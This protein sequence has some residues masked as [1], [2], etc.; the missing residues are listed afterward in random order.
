MKARAIAFYLPQYHPIPENDRWWGEGFTEWTN[1]RKANPLFRGHLQPRVPGSLGYYSLLSP[2]TRQ[3]QAELAALHGV[4]GFCYWHYWFAGKRLLERPFEEVLHSGQPALPFCL[5]WANESWTGIWH[6]APNRLLMEQTYPGSA[7]EERHFHTVAEAFFDERYL[8]V[9]GKPVFYVYKPQQIPDPCRFVEHWQTL[10]IKAGLQ[11]IYF[12]GEDVYIDESPWNPTTS[13][14]D[15]VV[16]NTP[17]VA[18]LRLA[19]K[20]T[21]RRLLSL[22]RRKLFPRPYVFDYEEFVEN[23]FVEE[24]A[25]VNYDFFPSVLPNW[26]NSPRSGTNA[27]VLVDATPQLFRRQL[28]K[29][30]NQVAHREKDKRLIFIKSWNEWAEGNFLEPDELYGNA[31]LEVCRD[32]ILGPP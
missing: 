21:P 6:G 5:G 31:Y 10:A 7:D 18:F 24:P 27:K 19:K 25:E 11:G 13:G 17:G 9:D 12:I 28:S 16:P 26:D 8:T 23:C 29:A 20:R 3:A 22:I 4:E 1:V 32:E 14:F 2:A 30:L 15:A